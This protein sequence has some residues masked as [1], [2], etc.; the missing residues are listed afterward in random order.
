MSAQFAV[1]IDLGTT[2][3]VLS[4][5]RLDAAAPQA[6]VFPVPQIVDRG[7]IEARTSLPSFTWLAT[8]AEA[9]AGAGNLPWCTGHDFVVGEYARRQAAEQPDRTVGAAK[10]WLCHHAVD[11]HSRILPWQSA[12]TVTK[13]SPVEASTRYL[14]H[15][16][17]AW[18]AEHPDA[19]LSKQKVVLT[20]P[21]S[22]DPV[23]RELTREAAVHA[24]LPDDLV[25]LEEPQAA[26]YA[27][28]QQM[29]DSWRETLAAGETL[30]VCDVGGGT[31]DLTLIDVVDEGGNLE[32][33]RRAV[34]DHLLVGGDN[35]DLLL[36]WTAAQLFEQQ[37]IRLDPW[38]SVSLWHSCRA[39][40]ERLLAED[41]PETQT[42]SVAGRG[43]RLIGGSVS[44]ELKREDIA[45]QLVEGFLPLVG[46]GDRPQRAMVTGFQE[47]GLPYESDTGI[48]RHIAEFLNRNSDGATLKPTHVLL[49]GGVFRSIR[50]RQQLMSV[51]A[52]W[53]D[54][55]TASPTLLSGVH[56]LENA[57]ALGAAYYAWVREHGALRIRGGSARS[58]YI[59]IETAGLA[60]PGAPR[61]LRALC[62]VPRGMEEGTECDV[63]SGPVGMAVGQPAK[64]R[65]FGSAVREDDR[66]G[67]LLNA[68]SSE[69]LV[70]TANLETELP[71][72]DPAET[73][74]PVTF[75]SRVTELGVLELWCVHHDSG[76][77]WKLELN[78]REDG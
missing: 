61:P 59:G 63:P 34:G 48:T 12:D 5:V 71:R 15:M 38:Q 32:L 74:V 27:W 46:P 72:E 11:R 3:C 51:L 13:I 78:V 24:G 7:T 26:V 53:Y 14:Q 28:L 64:F 54:D 18:D 30:L 56:D 50:L 42:V 68:W 60:I 17:S 36:A 37:G 65:F 20:V 8:P 33:R 9:E 69:E 73:W 1:G 52:H 67:S 39:A 21:A 16:V 49:N 22:F 29:G 19:P 25:L 41:G 76:R 43:S 57:V 47:L 66:P 2:N 58:W 6:S 77:R 62:V 10:S 55:Q 45:R 35:M 40:K 75:Q 4:W 44:I 31:T 23:A 70:E